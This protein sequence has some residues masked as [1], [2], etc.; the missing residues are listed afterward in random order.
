[1]SLQVGQLPAPAQSRRWEDWVEKGDGVSENHEQRRNEDMGWPGP[2]DLGPDSIALACHPGSV[3]RTQRLHL[4]NGTIAATTSRRTSY[5]DLQVLAHNTCS[6][7]ACSL[8]TTITAQLY[9]ISSTIR[10]VY[11]S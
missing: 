5:K 10:E 8:V 2:P 11:T 4:Q 3:P 1:M 6:V 7:S 9:S